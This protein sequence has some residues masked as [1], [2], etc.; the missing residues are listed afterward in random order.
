MAGKFEKLMEY[1]FDIAT[2]SCICWG[3]KYIKSLHEKTNIE[4]R[5][6]KTAS[7]EVES[8]VKDVLKE[9][10][11]PEQMINN[12]TLK[13]DPTGWWSPPSTYKNYFIMPDYDLEK[14]KK[15]ATWL[16]FSIC[17]E[18]GHIH[19][20]DVDKIFRFLVISPWIS[21]LGFKLAG[22]GVS[23]FFNPLRK[24]PK[25]NTFLSIGNGLLK[26]LSF[27]A[28]FTTVVLAY[29]FYGK[30]IE[31]Q[32]DTEAIRRIKDPE[33]LQATINHFHQKDEEMDNQIKEKYTLS[34]NPYVSM[35]KKSFLKH[36]VIY[37]GHPTPESRAKR[38]EEALK[39][40]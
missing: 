20:N 1:G 37:S 17:H 26:P 29:I 28:Q 7:P 19:H 25:L 32:A 38:F 33:I 34:K 3:T 5:K 2:V 4:V 10:N 11:Y 30:H 13:I 12:V 15:E 35:L 8:F 39:N 6:L 14:L 27:M 9:Y 18:G 23:Q 31:Y 16:K 36:I 21:W 24:S 22:R 40:L